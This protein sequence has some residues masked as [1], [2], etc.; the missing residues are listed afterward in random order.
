LKVH[1]RQGDEVAIKTFN[2]ITPGLRF[3]ETLH[4]EVDEKEPEKSLTKGL[5]S[6][7]DE[8]LG[9]ESVFEGEGADINGSTESLIL[10]ETNMGFQ[11]P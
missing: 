8:A 1:E 4:Y 6:K 9:V 2:P 7:A 11:L 10:N 3:A 5:S